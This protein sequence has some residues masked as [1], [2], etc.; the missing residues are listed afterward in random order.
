MAH[1]LASG[2]IPAQAGIHCGPSAGAA[3]RHRDVA[4][5]GAARS[6]ARG[7]S[8]LKKVHRT[9]FRGPLA[10]PLLT[11]IPALSTSRILASPSPGTGA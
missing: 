4:G 5:R 10:A 7:R 11:L 2:V 8:S 6:G 3:S 1:G 9:F